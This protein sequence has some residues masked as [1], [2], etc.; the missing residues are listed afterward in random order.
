MITGVKVH[1]HARVYACVTQRTDD[2]IERYVSLHHSQI[3]DQV[4][5]ALVLVHLGHPGHEIIAS[6]VPVG[7]HQRSAFQSTH[8]V[9]FF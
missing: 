4:G 5:S 1:M 7:A 8:I 3:V 2:Q 9:S 6:V